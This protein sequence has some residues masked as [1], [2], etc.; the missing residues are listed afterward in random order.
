MKAAKNATS[1]HVFV[2]NNAMVDV[3]IYAF[4][5]SKEKTRAA[6]VSSRRGGKGGRALQVDGCM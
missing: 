4:F 2:T 3:L 5:S 1:F 6:N